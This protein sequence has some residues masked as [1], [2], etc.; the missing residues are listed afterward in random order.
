M[1]LVL[2]TVCSLWFWSCFSVQGRKK[3]ADGSKAGSADRSQADDSSEGNQHDTELSELDKV[4]VQPWGLQG[5]QNRE[6]A[7]EA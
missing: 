1:P 6:D 7:I 4:G 3:K 5:R 2:S